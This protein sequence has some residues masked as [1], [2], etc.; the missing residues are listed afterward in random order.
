MAE[1]IGSAC[2]NACCYALA[3]SFYLDAINSDA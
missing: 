3:A 2:A 1:R